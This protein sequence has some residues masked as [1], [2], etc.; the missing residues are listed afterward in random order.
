VTKKI[1]LRFKQL[2]IVVLIYA[3][4]L[5]SFSFAKIIGLY[6]SEAQMQETMV[7]SFTNT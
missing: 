2:K 6:A 3:C 1:Y 5:V 4:K 7:I